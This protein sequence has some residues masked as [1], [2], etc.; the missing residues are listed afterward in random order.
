MQSTRY[1]CQILI[2]VEFSLEIFEKR[3]IIKFN[4]NSS[5]GSR[6]VHAD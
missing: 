6:V 3:S 1:S 2:A 4:Q 5:C